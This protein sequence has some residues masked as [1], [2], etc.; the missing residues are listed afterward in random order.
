MIMHFQSDNLT[1]DSNGG[2]SCRDGAE[3]Q[4]HI[5]WQDRLLGVHPKR[6]QPTVCTTPARRRD[7]RWSSVKLMPYRTISSDKQASTNP[8]RMTNNLIIYIDF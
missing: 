7:V 1:H 8:N 6:R 5:S 3:I 4:S 2:S